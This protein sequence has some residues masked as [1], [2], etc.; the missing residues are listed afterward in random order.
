[1]KEYVF[2]TA[3]P[4]DEDKDCKRWIAD[5]EK[6][7]EQKPAEWS[8]EDKNALLLFHELISFGYTENFCDAQ[9]AED[10]RRWL[11]ERLKSTRPQPHWKP[12]DVQMEALAWYSGNSGVPP[13]GDKA[14]KSLY[15]DLQKLL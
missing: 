4:F 13:T 15:I 12:S 9:T 6:Q 5:L 8:Q 3:G 7:K 10:M 11:N 1:M 2:T 14:I